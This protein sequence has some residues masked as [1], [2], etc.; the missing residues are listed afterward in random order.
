M[1]NTVLVTG[2]NGFLGS[3]VCTLLAQK[4]YTPISY[5]I[6][7]PRDACQF[8][9]KNHAATIKYVNGQI[10]DLSRVLAVCK[11]QHVNTIVHAAGFVDVAGSLEQPYHTYRVNTE[12]SIVIFEAARLLNL[13]RVVLISSNAVYHRKAYEPIDELHPVFSPAHGNLAGHY[14][15]SKLVSEIIGLTYCSFNG[16]DLLVLRM[17]SIY[18]FGMQNPMYIKPMVEST[19]LGRPCD[20]STGGEMRRDYTYVLDS[21]TGVLKATEIEGKGV[22]QRVLNVSG[23]RLYSAREVAEV[24][25]EVVPG[26]RISIGDG[27]TDIEKSDIQA[28]G[29]L[30]C[31]KAKEVLGY[32]AEYDLHRG[33]REYVALMREYL[34]WKEEGGSKNEKDI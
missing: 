20:F 25:R 10:T 9:H 3:Y 12:G 11:E 1:N 4:G 32:S 5:D 14:G 31:R 7:P 2:G 29:V 24:V 34:Q 6:A 18:G 8:I 27:L 19:V 17:S 15:A 22:E 21:A 23:G 28:R 16:V 26:A 33:V 30:D 13:R